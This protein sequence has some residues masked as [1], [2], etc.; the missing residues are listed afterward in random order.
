MWNSGAIWCSGRTYQQSVVIV[1]VTKTKNCFRHRCTWCCQSDCNIALRLSASTLT[2]SRLRT[3]VTLTRA[4]LTCATH[5][6]AC[7][8]WASKR[9]KRVS[10]ARVSVDADGVTLANVCDAYACYAYACDAWAS[11][12]AKRDSV[13]RVSVPW[14]C[15]QCRTVD[16]RVK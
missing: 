11:K 8:A 3:C 1:F 12:N 2:A 14:Y 7:D 6:H 16:G 15:S 9:A 13:A 4:W 10:V 5:E